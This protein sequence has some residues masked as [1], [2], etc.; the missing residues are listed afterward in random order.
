[1]QRTAEQIADDIA[2]I[3]MIAQSLC[4]RGS[5][6]IWANALRELGEK[7]EMKGSHA[8]IRWS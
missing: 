4:P 3:I 5:A 7:A 8:E 1:M 6:S 2:D